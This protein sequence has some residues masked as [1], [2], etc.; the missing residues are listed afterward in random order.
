MC[1]LFANATEPTTKLQNWEEFNICFRGCRARAG[2][3][4]SSCTLEC[5][6]GTETEQWKNWMTCFGTCRDTGAHLASCM[7]KC[8]IEKEKKVA[9]KA[10]PKE[11]TAWKSC[12]NSCRSVENKGWWECTQ[13]CKSTTGET[14]VKAEEWNAWKSCWD[15][16]RSNGSGWLDCSEQCSAKDQPQTQAADDFNSW[17]TCFDNCFNTE[18][19]SWSECL[20]QCGSS[21]AMA[22]NEAENKEWIGWKSCYETCQASGANWWECSKQC[23]SAGTN[24]TSQKEDWSSWKACWESCRNEDGNSW[25]SCVTQCDS[26]RSTTT[27][28]EAKADAAYLPE[29]SVDECFA[30]CQTSGKSQ[31]TCIVLCG[32][33]SHFKT[34]EW[35]AWKS[36][37]ST[38]RTQEGKGWS[39]CTEECGAK[40]KKTANKKDVEAKFEIPDILANSTKK[41]IIEKTR[42]KSFSKIE[43][44]FQCYQACRSKGENA[45]LCTERCA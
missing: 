10:K 45:F 41:P 42:E 31:S 1:A 17:N 40:M 18:K 4:Y 29:A 44:S 20:V 14:T 15:K 12:W 19:K 22:T 26:A 39:A 34:E 24:T 23:H 6:T 2:A 9:E 36:C 33:D 3:S 35:N 16:C 7:E 13:Q 43:A 37:W 21:A 27:K 5:S 38:C 8:P 25:N 30:N 11:W 32:A 28:T